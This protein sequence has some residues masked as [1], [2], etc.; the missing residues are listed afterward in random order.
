M[1]ALAQ[2]DVIKYKAELM[3][4]AKYGNISNNVS[5]KTPE[6]SAVAAPPTATSD[7]PAKVAMNNAAAPNNQADEG[8]PSKITVPSSETTVPSVEETQK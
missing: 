2:Q 6:P 5:K 4:L 3:Q 8:P 7:V 1:Q